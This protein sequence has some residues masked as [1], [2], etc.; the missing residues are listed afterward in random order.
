M[1]VGSNLFNLAALVGLSAIVAHGIRVRRGPLIVDA[2]VGLVVMLGAI[3][4]VAG[5]VPP[6]AAAVALLALG[7]G[8][9]VVLAAPGH[10][11]PD[12]LDTTR[13]LPATQH[14][15]WLPVALLPPAIVGVVGGSYVMV[16]AALALAP[17]LHMSGAVLGIILL[18]GLTSL[19]NLWVALH[20]AR[21]DRGTALY[22][23]A[24]NSNSI[25]LVGG[26]VMPAIFA[27]IAA[28]RSSLPYFAWLLDLTL[29]AVLAPLPSG[30]LSRTAGIAV[31]FVY[32]LFVAIK[33]AGA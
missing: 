32:L 13:D 7:A 28:S 22:A 26:L 17:A 21:A 16:H 10:W 31:I 25:N 14:G 9:V 23:A 20:F 12:A 5:A 3:G 1:V 2:A 30:R 27:G 33:L 11:V 15:S 4:V 6:L 18:A 8:Y 19:P 24:L 29:L